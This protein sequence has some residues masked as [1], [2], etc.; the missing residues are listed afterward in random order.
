MIRFLLT[1]AS[2]L[3]CHSFL[4]ALNT[5]P[6]YL[7]VV[8]IRISLLFR[9]NEHLLCIYLSTIY[10][11]VKY[12]MSFAHFLIGSFAFLLLSFGSSPC[13]LDYGSSK[14]NKGY[15]LSFHP[16]DGV[17]MGGPFTEQKT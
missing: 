2:I 9:K 15:S 14:R 4:T 1:L 17:S 11:S 13:V 6:G 10:L 3:Y 8:L 16:V 5:V 12:L 7:I